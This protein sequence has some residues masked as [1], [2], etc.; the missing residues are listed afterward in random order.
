MRIQPVT[1]HE[2]PYP[3]GLSLV[4]TTDLKGRILHANSAFVT[5]SGYTLEELLGQP[6]NILRHPDVPE[7]AFRDMW[8]TIQSG[9]PWSGV[10]KNR[11]K[12]GDHY[13]VM[14]NVTPLL[15]GGRPVAYLSV[16]TQPTRAQ[17][18]AADKLYAQMREEA[19]A[20]H[21]RHRLDGGELIRPGLAALP[22]RVLRHQPWLR[23]I[24]AYLLSTALG[25]AA[26]AAAGP[27]AAV[28]TAG[29]SAVAFAAWRYRS[30]SAGLGHV[31]HFANA[32][33]AGDL[34]VTMVR[35][36]RPYTRHLERTL[37]QVAVN[38][39]AMVSDTRSEIDRIRQVSHEIAQGNQDLAQRTENQAASLQNTASSMDQ[40]AN[41]V[42]GTSS[43][44]Q[45]ASQVAG[46]LHDVSRR[47]A[48]VVHSVSD[49]MGG[50]AGSSHR[51][52][53]IVQ[54]ID[55]IA[56]QTNLLAL[57]AAVEAARAGE[58]GKG[59]AVVAGEVRALAQRSS[60]AAREI[61]GLIDE[62]TQR[63]QAGEEQTRAARASI[64]ATLDQVR[65]F[66]ALIGNIDASAHAQ[67][68][69]VA[70]VHESIRH[71]DGITQQNASMVEQLA[72]AASHMLADTEHVVASLRV[73]RLAA[74]EARSQ[75]DAVDLRR[76]HKAG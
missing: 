52:G 18:E 47:S 75:P 9:R 72:R 31:E 51:I 42:R 67:L 23:D 60:V 41:S 28:G 16:R 63:V 32:L 12:D 14:A 43:E 24:P 58:H 39:R 49:T 21:L 38:L 13:W 50:I 54:L 7:E 17:I 26:Y 36:G 5:T 76:Q 57:N 35:S 10:V 22:L 15:E 62:S 48:D 74:N 1:Q 68:G 34:S 29:L 25:S 66:T 27:W 45:A 69:D 6:H 8:A 11:R 4:S 20:G 30:L 61:K 3:S 71:L 64:D 56:F 2:F 44:T 55:S 59:F 65:A 73:F 40:I 33:A 70:Q 46:E 19:R 37:A 53:E